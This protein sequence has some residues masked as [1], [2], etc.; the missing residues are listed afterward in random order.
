MAKRRVNATAKN[1]TIN[2]KVSTS[3]HIDGGLY[4]SE[5]ERKVRA[6]KDG[7]YHL[8]AEQGF[9]YEEIKIS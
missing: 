2:I 1:D 4:R 3:I 5:Q 6:F 9:H 7:L 8:L